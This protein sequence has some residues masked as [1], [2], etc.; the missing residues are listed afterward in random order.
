MMLKPFYISLLSLV[1]TGE[2]L[3]ND[4]KQVRN[5]DGVVEFSNADIDVRKPTSINSNKTIIYKSLSNDGEG[6]SFSDKKPLNGDFEVLAYE[7]YACNPT[8]KINWHTISLNTADY[9]DTVRTIAKKYKI[10]AALVRA[11]IHA[12]SAFNAKAL[13]KKGAQG[14]MQL[15]PGTAKDL[16]VTNAF[17]VQ[18]NIE[19]G[20]KYLAGLLHTFDGDIK[21]A[22]AAYNAGP[23]AV[24]RFKGIPP[25]AETEVYVERVGILHQRYGQEG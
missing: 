13:S 1:L 15:M 8:S 4:I 5:S 2:V 6:F 24:K 7:C 18:Q 19:G 16:G 11:V 23:G 21:L 22:T 14:L 10:D 9:A 12:E 3:A 20:V 17:D 25:Y